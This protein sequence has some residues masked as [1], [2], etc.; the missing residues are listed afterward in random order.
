MPMI[1]KLLKFH[2]DKEAKRGRSPKEEE[3]ELE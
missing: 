3:S 2:A 1:N